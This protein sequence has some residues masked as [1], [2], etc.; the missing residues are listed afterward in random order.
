MCCLP[1][2]KD[3]NSKA[4]HN[5]LRDIKKDDYAVCRMSKIVRCL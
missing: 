4:I 1:Y 5:E 3:S 2:V